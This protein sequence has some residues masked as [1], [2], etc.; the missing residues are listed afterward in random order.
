VLAGPVAVQELVRL[1]HPLLSRNVSLSS[2][3]GRSRGPTITIRGAPDLLRHDGQEELTAACQPMLARAVAEKGVDPD[4]L[5]LGD[6][7]SMNV[8]TR[9]GKLM[10]R[11]ISAAHEGSRYAGSF[12]CRRLDGKVSLTWRMS[13]VDPS[14]TASI[15]T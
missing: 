5:V 14:A 4:T 3:V 12:T 10:E 13:P 8:S 7:L 11:Q 1:H 9:E 6:V 2:K 15:R